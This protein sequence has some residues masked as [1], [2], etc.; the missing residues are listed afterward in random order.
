MN[1][2]QH[3]TFPPSLLLRADHGH[4][5]VDRRSFMVGMGALVASPPAVEAQQVGKAYRIG[6]LT[7]S[8]ADRAAH[9]IVAFE[10]RLRELGYVK[11]STITYEH[12]F[13]GGRTERLP[14]IARELSALNLDVIIAGNNASI[15]ARLRSQ[16]SRYLGKGSPL[17][18]TGPHSLAI[19]RGRPHL[20]SALPCRFTRG[21]RREPHVLGR[22]PDSCADRDDEREAEASRHHFA[23]H[24]FPSRRRAGDANA[25][26]ATLRLTLSGA[27]KLPG[28]RVGARSAC[29]HA[30]HCPR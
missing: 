13:A 29:C 12:R 2:T 17:F 4:R 22:R 14:E 24:S 5:I 8:P 15:A 27:T 10:E 26:A 28:L 25:S 20:F 30:R 16:P 21:Q 19:C 9:F 23:A 7:V 3:L 18:Q 1:A 11:G 6:T